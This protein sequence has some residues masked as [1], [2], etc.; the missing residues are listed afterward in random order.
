MFRPYRALWWGARAI[1]G[2]RFALPLARVAAR[3]QRAG[4]A[5]GGVEWMSR[6]TGNAVATEQYGQDVPRRHEGQAGNARSAG[7][8]RNRRE[9]T[10]R[11]SRMPV[12]RMQRF[13][14]DGSSAKGA[15]MET[16]AAC[17]AGVPTALFGVPRH[18]REPLQAG[19]LRYIEESMRC[20]DPNAHSLR[21]LRAFV[22]NVLTQSRKEAEPT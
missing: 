18:R 8:V 16:T 11:N 10:E 5:R 13:G 15:S 6:Q 12:A 22:V 3:F 1:Q 4:V 21:A 7:L 14:A 2:R 17:S 9:R 20:S 19:R